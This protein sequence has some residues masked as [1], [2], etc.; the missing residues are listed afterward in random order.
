[1]NVHGAN[2]SVVNGAPHFGQFPKRNCGNPVGDLLEKNCERKCPA[3]PLLSLIL[4]SI[5][6]S[7][8]LV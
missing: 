1:M 7:P 6:I 2:S 3:D 4:I 8:Y 5:D